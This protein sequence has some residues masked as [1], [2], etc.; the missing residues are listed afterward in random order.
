M[1]HY[2]GL[3]VALKE[4]AICVI[5]A[6]G[7]VVWQG[8]VT[9]LLEAIVSAL[10][11]HAPELARAGNLPPPDDSARRRADHGSGFCG[12]NRRP[13]SLSACE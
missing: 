7:S 11:R 6:D 1:T 4:T 2:A 9:T 10:A 5:A 12:G 8:K 13:W 3:D